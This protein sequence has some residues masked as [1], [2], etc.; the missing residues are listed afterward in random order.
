M[1]LYH[2]SCSQLLP[3]CILPSYSKGQ[4]RVVTISHALA[5][6]ETAQKYVRT[7]FLFLVVFLCAQKIHYAMAIVFSLTLHN[8]LDHAIEIISN[9]G[10][11]L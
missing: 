1:Q 2:T 7:Q 10:A 11:R 5:V 3:Y 6:G 8:S 9:N 4:V